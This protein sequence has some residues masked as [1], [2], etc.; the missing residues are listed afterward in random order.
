ML[1]GGGILTVFSSVRVDA[2]TV[3]GAM[4]ILTKGPVMAEVSSTFIDVTLT[5]FFPKT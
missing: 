2:V 3:I 1:I 5:H 4:C